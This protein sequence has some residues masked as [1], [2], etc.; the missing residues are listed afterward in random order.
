M[1]GGAP[2]SRAR[3]FAVELTKKNAAWAFERGEPFQAIA[4]LE[5]Y[6]T[7]VSIMVFG[8]QWPKGAGG[9]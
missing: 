4:A 7:L 2:P 9:A 1:P 6:T 5:L 3:W 8:D